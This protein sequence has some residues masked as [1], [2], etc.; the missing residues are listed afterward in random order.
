MTLSTEAADIL[1]AADSDSPIRHLT[2]AEGWAIAELKHAGMVTTEWTHDGRIHECWVTRTDVGDE[3][4]TELDHERGE[5]DDNHAF[6]ADDAPQSC[7]ACDMIVHSE[8]YEPPELEDFR[9]G[10]L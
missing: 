5:H 8:E 2:E 9:M 4:L 1:A 10:A 7:S 6:Y 3:A